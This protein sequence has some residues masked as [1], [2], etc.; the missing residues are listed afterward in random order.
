MATAHTTTST[1]MVRLP[2]HHCTCASKSTCNARARWRVAIGARFAGEIAMQKKPSFAPIV[3]FLSLA[4]LAGCAGGDGSTL[5]SSRDVTF[6]GVTIS[7]PA[8]W[9]P[10][11]GYETR[12]QGESEIGR[13]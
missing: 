8:D 13:A 9:T 3:L 2:P 12:V 5:A 11:P 10:A 6:H 1:S 7:V 4:C